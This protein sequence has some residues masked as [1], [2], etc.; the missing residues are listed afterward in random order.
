MIITILNVLVDVVVVV[1]VGGGVT[2]HY[3]GPDFFIH[4]NEIVQQLQSCWAELNETTLNVPFQFS[5]GENCMLY[6][7]INHLLSVNIMCIITKNYFIIFLQSYVGQF[8]D[9]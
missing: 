3:S 7:Y 9:M 5:R 1:V 8:I 6:L 4:A 2:Y